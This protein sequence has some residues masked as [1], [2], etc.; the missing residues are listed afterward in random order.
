MQGAAVSNPHSN[1]TKYI[2]TA[3]Q[4]GRETESQ[5]NDLTSCS[6]TKLE[7]NK[8][9]FKLLGDPV[10]FYT[11]LCCS[12]NIC[13]Q[14]RVSTEQGPAPRTGLVKRILQNRRSIGETCGRVRG[15]YS[16]NQEF[17]R[18]QKVNSVAKAENTGSEMALERDQEIEPG[19]E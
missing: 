1:S 8:V 19:K 6:Q 9:E 5:R 11:P 3:P 18:V 10:A 4:S 13:W 14:L 2:L 16:Q 15:L 17:G 12:P 7:M